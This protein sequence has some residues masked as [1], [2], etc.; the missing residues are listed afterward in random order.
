MTN[1]NKYIYQELLDRIIEVQKDLYGKLAIKTAAKVKEIEISGNGK[2]VE[3]SG[4]PEDAVR[5][6]I[7]EYTALGGKLSKSANEAILEAYRRQYPS[8][9]LPEG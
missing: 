9:N 6:L 3:I 5:N 1:E 7:R 2:V 8:I 4:S